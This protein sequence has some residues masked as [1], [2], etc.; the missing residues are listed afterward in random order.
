MLWLWISGFNR[1][2]SLDVMPMAMSGTTWHTEDRADLHIALGD[3]A[4]TYLSRPHHPSIASGD[5]YVDEF[6]TRHNYQ[7]QHTASPGG[8]REP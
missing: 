3:T 1:L 4:T 7:R 6:L 8:R 2:L 5:N